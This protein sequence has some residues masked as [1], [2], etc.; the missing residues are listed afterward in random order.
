MALTFTNSLFL[1]KKTFSNAL[2]C[3]L[4]RCKS[5]VF[6][7][8]VSPGGGTTY[9]PVH[10][11]KHREFRKPADLRSSDFAQFIIC[12]RAKN[13]MNFGKAVLNNVELF[14]FCK[15]STKSPG[16]NYRSRRIFTR[17]NRNNGS[18]GWAKIF[19]RYK[20]YWVLVIRTFLT[21]NIEPLQFYQACNICK[22]RCF[23]Q[24][25]TRLNV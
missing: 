15:P 2:K 18:F 4:F 25:V 5:V 14:I 11:G 12:W 21:R 17:S 3:A 16:N 1:Q 13:F 8:V 6:P 9:Q 10:R 19:C 20:S 23:W 7:L 24:F 22:N